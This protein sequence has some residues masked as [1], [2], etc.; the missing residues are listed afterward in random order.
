MT[1]RKIFLILI[2]TFFFAFP[3]PGTAFEKEAVTQIDTAEKL[4]TVIEFEST[5]MNRRKEEVLKILGEP[6]NKDKV[7]DK[8][9][10]KY[11]Q[12][13]K[14]RKKSGTRTSCSILAGSITSGPTT[15]NNRGYF[16]K[17]NSICAPMNPAM[18]PPVPAAMI[19]ISLSPVL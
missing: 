18:A 1:S 13:V 5:F 16:L 14:I 19:N 7:Q 3:F 8:E 15:A 2:F 4:F 10:R 11:K 9:V 6:D 12:V 17:N